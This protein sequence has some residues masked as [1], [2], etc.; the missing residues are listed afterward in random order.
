[1]NSPY[2]QDDYVTLY[3]GDATSVDEWLSADVLVTDPP[4]GMS[5]QSNASKY[6][7]PSARIAGDDTLELRDALL[8][9]WGDK[10]ALVFGT[11]RVD[12]PAGTKQL[13]VWDKGDSPG[14]GDLSIPW[15]PSHEEVYVLGSG[16]IG[17]RGG[18]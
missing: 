8:G 5:Y 13:I 16:F 12:R 6:N 18:P 15:G 10:P 1:M 3:H 4:Y 14:M 17:K 9:M 7:G 11:W 2:Y